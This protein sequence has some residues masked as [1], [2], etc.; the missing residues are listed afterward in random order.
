[1]QLVF[2]KQV[3]KP[4]ASEVSQNQQFCV[5]TVRLPVNL[6][7]SVQLNFSNK[8]EGVEWSHW[9]TQWVLQGSMPAGAP[10]HY[11]VLMATGYS[12]DMCSAPLIGSLRLE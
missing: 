12:R 9:E 3:W 8:S 4:S 5:A 10:E 1:M 6:L 2:R 7:I 11:S